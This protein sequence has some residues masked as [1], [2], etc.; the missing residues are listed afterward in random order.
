MVDERLLFYLRDNLAKGYAPEQLLDF[1]VKQGYD[2]TVVRDGL[3]V[4]QA[5]DDKV[6]GSSSSDVSA[7][8]AG[9]PPEVSFTPQGNFFSRSF[10]LLKVSWQVVR[11]NRSMLFLPLLSALFS[12]VFII[13]MLFPTILAFIGDEGEGAVSTILALGIYLGLAFIAT[14]FNTALVF[15]AREKLAGRDSSVGKAL[16]FAFSKFGVILGWS[17]LSATV[18][19]LLR[20][21]ENLASKVPVAGQIIILILQKVMG[22]L[23][24]ILTLFAIPVMVYEDVGPFKA[25]RRS[26][27]VLRKA[28]G[29]G[30]M[31]YFGLGG[32]Y[33]L[34]IVLG[35]FLFGSGLFFAGTT[36]EPVVMGL[37]LILAVVYFVGGVLFLETI[38]KVFFTALYMYASTGVVAD[39][40]PPQMLASAFRPKKHRK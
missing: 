36:G 14:F 6:W 1:L 5:D 38:N 20:F 9:G 18:G 26:S 2:E 23:W 11:K 30:F 32:V 40:F 37:G 25:L 19:L 15:I 8:S 10:R 16:G 28:W 33:L 13:A 27:L 29:E 17:L 4:A 31:M 22:L 24:S 3:K 21:L 12:F 39:G 7:S 34:F 35:G